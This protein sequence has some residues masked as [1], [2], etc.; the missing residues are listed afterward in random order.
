MQRVQFFV[1]AMLAILL[2]ATWA[3]ADNVFVGIEVCQ[4]CHEEQYERFTKYSKKA[5]SNRSVQVMA[6]DLTDAEL[7][8][9][10]TCH[11]TGYGQPGGFVSYD[12]TPHLGIVGCETCH[13]PGHEHV[14]SGGDADLIQRT[15]TME[16]C[17]TCH[18][19]ERVQAFNFKPLIYSGAH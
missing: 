3:N 2:A 7:K 1:L 6:P 17:E 11:T 19:A 16:D 10:Y 9:C 15:M 8:Q 14:E 4:D 12:E 13:G 5:H 18:N